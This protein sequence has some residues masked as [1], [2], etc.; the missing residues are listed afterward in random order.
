GRRSATERGCG[1]PACGAPP[2]DTPE[3]RPRRS[4][5]SA[6]GARDR[7]GRA[8]GPAPARCDRTRRIEAAQ[9]SILHRPVCPVKEP[10]RAGI[11]GALRSTMTRRA[12]GSHPKGA[13]NVPTIPKALHEH[14]DTAFPTFVCLVGTVL[15]SGFAQISP[16]GS[17]M[18]LDDEHLAL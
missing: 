18:V 9:G 13:R 8:R 11:R 6:R 2:G 1:W 15:P 10:R 5:R 7:S 12:S 4:A 17:T 3:I 16:R 14:I